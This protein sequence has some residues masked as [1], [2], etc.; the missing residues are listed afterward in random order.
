MSKWNPASGHEEATNPLESGQ[1]SDGGEEAS[2]AEAH[3][4]W[5]NQSAYWY[6]HP[7]IHHPGWAPLC[8]CF[9]SSSASHP[10]IC[11]WRAVGSSRLAAEPPDGCRG[12]GL[13]SAGSRHE[14]T[15]FTALAG[16]QLLPWRCVISSG[17]WEREKDSKVS[18][19]NRS[20]S[21][22]QRG[23]D[24][25]QR[26]QMPA[27]ALAAGASGPRSLGTRS[28]LRCSSTPSRLLKSSEPVT[29]ARA[30]SKG[31][32]CLGI[33]SSLKQQLFIHPVFPKRKWAPADGGMCSFPL[34]CQCL[35]I[36]DK[37]RLQTRKSTFSLTNFLLGNWPFLKS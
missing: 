26:L 24:D 33:G 32:K 31:Q 28:S 13:V 15:T 34:C 1:R 19:D 9:S 14:N 16:V 18:T 22:K 4:G 10:L 30:Q 21:P 35:H 12:T 36:S 29:I 5:T 2:A 25:L 20:R 11:Y 3:R 8:S 17:L 23:G 37:L 7:S 6:T 27:S